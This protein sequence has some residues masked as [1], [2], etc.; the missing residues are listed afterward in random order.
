MIALASAIKVFDIFALLSKF[1]LVDIH[2]VRVIEHVRKRVGIVNVADF[3]EITT[4][5]QGS[6]CEGPERQLC[7][8]LF[9]G[10]VISSTDE[11]HVGIVEAA[12]ACNFSFYLV[13]DEV[14]LNTVEAIGIL[15]PMDIKA[16]TPR[17]SERW[18]PLSHIFVTI[19]ADGIVHWTLNVCDLIG[20]VLI[21]FLSWHAPIVAITVLDIVNSPSIPKIN[22]F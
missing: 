1:V 22:I 17:L 13:S 19:V 14:R 5:D 8:L 18:C 21:S 3:L 11:E 12:W 4:E 2:D 6:L 15:A 16:C 9:F 20:H 10:H 7:L